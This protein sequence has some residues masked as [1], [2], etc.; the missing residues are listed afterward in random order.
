ML[1]GAR[2]RTPRGHV[3]KFGH[4]TSLHRVDLSVGA[5]RSRNGS[6]EERTGGVLHKRFY[7]KSIFD[8]DCSGDQEYEQTRSDR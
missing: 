7:K 5:A 1:F 4:I 8:T 2:P 6:R 3:N